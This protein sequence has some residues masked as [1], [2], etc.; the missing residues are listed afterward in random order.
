[1]VPIP[2]TKRADRLGENAAAAGAEL[3]PA[4]L[5]RLETAVPRDAWSGDRQ[6]FAAH[7]VTRAAPGG[8][9]ELP[10]RSGRAAVRATPMTDW[11]VLSQAGTAVGTLVLASA[12]FATV[13]SAN[14]TARVAERTLLAGLRPALVPAG[15]DDPAEPVQF[16]DGRVLALT[17]GRATIAETAGVI[18]LA[19][20]LRNVG[21]GLAVLRGYHLEAV[22]ARQ[23][24][25]DPHGPARHLRGDLAPGPAAFRRQQRDLYV[26]PGRAGFWQAALRDPGA[27]LHAAMSEAIRT[28]GRITVDL[29]YGDHDGGQPT[30]TRFVL[31][32]GEDQRWRCDVT[33]HWNLAASKALHAFGFTYRS[34]RYSLRTPPVRGEPWRG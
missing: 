9:R 24:A 23:A 33:R 2:G 7:R 19:I 14:R 1:V 3:S 12:T 29:L 28:S 21:A 27:G 22:P 11:V 30:I 4:D 10:R 34:V 6:S 31:L 17:A 26:P 16:A 32:P 5:A 13:R 18:Y 20:P 15:P 8:G 25:A